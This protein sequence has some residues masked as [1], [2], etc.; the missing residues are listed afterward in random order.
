VKLSTGGER[1]DQFAAVGGGTKRKLIAAKASTVSCNYGTNDLSAGATSATVINTLFQI[2]SYFTGLAQKVHPADVA[3]TRQLHRWPSHNREPVFP[4]HLFSS[5]IGIEG[6]RR[7]VNN[8]LLSNGGAQT[9]ADQSMFASRASGGPATSLYTGDGTARVFI[10]PMPFVQGSETIK[11]AGVAKALTTDYA[12]TDTIVINGVAYASAVTL[13]SAAANAAMVTVSGISIPS[14]KSLLGPLADVIDWASAVEVDANG[15]SGTN[16]GFWKTDNSTLDSGT[17]SGSNSTNTVNDTTKSWAV[18]QWRGYTV[19]I[20]SDPG[21]PSATGQV[22]VIGYNTATRLSMSGSGRR[23]PAIKPNTSST[24]DG[25]RTART[26]RR[27]ATWLWGA[28]T[29]P[30]SQSSCDL[31]HAPSPDIHRSPGCMKGYLNA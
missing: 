29:K 19:L 14:F 6:H 28:W 12:Y 9:L 27:V 25:A 24:T 16:G 23:Y 13:N 4:E 10:A 26:P 3:T 22:G 15:V 2:G 1:G 21:N 8:V 30:T 5:T 18:D 7:A 20:A 17:S 31:S 11:V